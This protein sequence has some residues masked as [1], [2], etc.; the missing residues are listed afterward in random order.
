LLFP[1]PIFLGK[2]KEEERG[3]AKKR[4]LSTTAMKYCDCVQSGSSIRLIER[5]ETDFFRR[6]VK[7]GH[8]TSLENFIN[9]KQHA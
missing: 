5:K 3:I 7:I 1:R 4:S 2:K 9:H 8:N 6:A